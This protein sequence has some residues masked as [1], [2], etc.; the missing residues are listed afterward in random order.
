MTAFLTAL[1]ELVT[2]WKYVLTAM[3]AL[4]MGFS[5]GTLWGKHVGVS[6]CNQTA[7]VKTVNKVLEI[8]DNEDKV[9]AQPH[10]VAATIN[11]LYNGTD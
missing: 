3:V 4:W 2:D 11:R 10:D 1:K 9:R 8:K 6:S 5:L 7:E